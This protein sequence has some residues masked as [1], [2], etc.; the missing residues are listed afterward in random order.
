MRPLTPSEAAI[1]YINAYNA[2]DLERLRRGYHD[3]FTVEN[4]LW[5]GTKSVDEVISTFGRVWDAL[6]GA[7]M[8]LYNLAV[9]GDTALLEFTFAWDDPRDGTT[10][11][12][13][14]ADVFTV[15][16]GLLA[17][18]RAYMD[19]GLFHGWLDEMSQ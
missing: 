1:E 5:E 9:D 15:K 19:A 4:P 17:N 6:P 3:D 12:T 18:L 16:D 8:E 2:H 7:R 14:V 11:R 10:K 13:P